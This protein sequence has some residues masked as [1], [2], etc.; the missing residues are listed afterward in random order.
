MWPS[1][2]GMRS[3]LPVPV[4]EAGPHLLVRHHE[5]VDADVASARRRCCGSSRSGSR[6]RCRRPRGS[7][8][9]RGCAA[10]RVRDVVVVR[11]R[12]SARCRCRPRSPAGSCSAHRSSRRAVLAGHAQPLVVRGRVASRRR[13]HVGPDHPAG[14][15]GRVGRD[16]DAEA[17]LRVRRLRGHVDAGALACRTSSRGTR[18][19]VRTLRY[20]RRTAAQGGARS[21]PR[22]G[23]RRRRSRGRRRGPRRGAGPARAGRQARGSPR[24]GRPAASSGG[25]VSPI[26]VPGPTRVR[27]S[28]NS[29]GDVHRPS[30]HYEEEL[31]LRH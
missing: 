28:F 3:A 8:A 25:R 14:L 11:E 22:R 29:S 21:T 31:P 2:L 17:E 26:G 5:L 18:S 7:G 10:A 27:R 1:R 12:A 9:G 23:R 6:S 20:G 19:E 15:V 24:R 16:R 13:A 30:L 4:H